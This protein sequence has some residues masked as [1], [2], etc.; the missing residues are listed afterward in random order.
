MKDSVNYSI[1][2][3]YMGDGKE[4]ELCQSKFCVHSLFGFVLF[5]LIKVSM[6]LAL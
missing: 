1:V 5:F 4:L 2:F 3:T 6:S